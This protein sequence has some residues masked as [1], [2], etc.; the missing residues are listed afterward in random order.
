MKT[1]LIILSIAFISSCTPTSADDLNIYCTEVL[2]KGGVVMVYW[3]EYP[4]IINTNIDINIDGYDGF[5][6]LHILKLQKGWEIH[7]QKIALIN[8]EYGK[9][10]LLNGC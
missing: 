3:S 10:S 6:I 8:F 2:N 4:G 7:S 9:V 1:L 5:Y